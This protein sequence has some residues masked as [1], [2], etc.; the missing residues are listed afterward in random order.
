MF[1]WI[2]QA[3]AQTEVAV[4]EA[5]ASLTPAVAPASAGEAFMMNM[6]LVL[7]VIMMFYFLVIRPQQKRLRVHTDM[8]S[9]L[10]KGARVVMQGGMIGTIVDQVSDAEVILD[11]NGQKLTV[12]RSAIMG[13]FEDIVAPATVALKP[14]A[15]DTA[16]L[17]A[18]TKAPKKK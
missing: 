3:Y 10:G 9:H 14:A 5:T 7:L 1:N 6:M 18:G 15:N 12:L 13:K 11:C 4:P 16:K 8:L 17:K 2:S